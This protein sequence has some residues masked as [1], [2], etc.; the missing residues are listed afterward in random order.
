ML[1]N[2]LIEYIPEYDGVI[3]WMAWSTC[4]SEYPISRTL[5]A[6]TVSRWLLDWCP[7]QAL[8]WEASTF[9][10]AGNSYLESWLVSRF[11]SFS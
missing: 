8:V 10:S 2:I 1:S 3:L 6:A 11:F 5:L 4:S 9:C 7:T